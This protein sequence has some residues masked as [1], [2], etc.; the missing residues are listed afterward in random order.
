M[1]VWVGGCLMVVGQ[2]LS[3]VE[4]AGGFVGVV[5]WVWLGRFGWMETRCSKFHDYDTSNLLP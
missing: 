3:L 5:L 1:W 4:T 2:H